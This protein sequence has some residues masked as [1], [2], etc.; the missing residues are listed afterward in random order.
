MKEEKN[1][2]VLK[3]DEKILKDLEYALLRMSKEEKNRLEGVSL[4]IVMMT[5]TRK[6]AV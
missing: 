6:S 3:S 5:E 4:A 1:V 2:A